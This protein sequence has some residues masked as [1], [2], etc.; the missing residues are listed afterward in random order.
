MPEKIGD[1]VDR[2][3]ARDKLGGQAVAQ[4][5]RTSDAADLYAAA[6]QPLAYDPRNGRRELEWS[7]RRRERQEYIRTIRLRPCAQDIVGDG[8]AGL[9]EKRRHAIALAL[10]ASDK[11]LRRISSRCP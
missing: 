5:V 2:P 1:L 6:L 3:A 9:V 8:R 7:Y 4:E 11:N 10:G